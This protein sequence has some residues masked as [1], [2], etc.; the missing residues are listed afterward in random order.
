[1]KITPLSIAI[2]AIVTMSTAW[3]DNTASEPKKYASRLEKIKNTNKIVFAVRESGG[4]FAF[5]DGND[6]FLGY[7]VE[8]CEGFAKSLLKDLALPWLDI[9]YMPVDAKERMTV[10]QKGEADIECG[11][12]THTEKRDK[13]NAFSVD[14]MAIAV[15]FAA[16]KNVSI[17][18]D[19]QLRDKK[20]AVGKNTVAERFFKNLGEQKQ[21]NITI[22]PYENFRD[23]ILAVQNASADLAA[24]DDSIIASN[25]AMIPGAKDELH[26]T[27]GAGYA[28]SAGGLVLPKG[29]DAFKSK[30]DNY[31]RRI[32][33]ETPPGK[34]KPEIY[35][36]YERWFLKPTPPK[37]I[38]VNLP[39]SVANIE[40]F[41]NPQDKAKIKE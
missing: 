31:L 37:G 18:N 17:S 36:I 12:T 32:M 39:M 15:M 7:S 26:L 1:M 25:L 41:K 33:T 16:K 10:V 2:A 9:V 22:V 29:D 35:D 3:A 8:L 23:A 21:L 11:S 4:V 34:A 40:G 24:N 14:V 5:N 19:A 20:I 38:V 6:N 27:G 30:V 13:D 28:I